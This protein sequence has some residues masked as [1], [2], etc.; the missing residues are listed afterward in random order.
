MKWADIEHDHGLKDMLE[1]KIIVVE[2][3]K[4]KM[5]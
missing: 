2:F 5:P 4:R 1:N 3:K